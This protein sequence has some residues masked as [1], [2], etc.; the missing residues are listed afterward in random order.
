MSTTRVIDLRSD[1]FTV[2][3]DGM[4]RAMAAAEVGD[5]VWGE[6]PTVNRLEEHVAALL[7]KQAAMY[8]PSGTMGNLVS[9]CAQ[10][11]P[12]DEIVVDR[13]SHLVVYEVAGAAVVGGVQMRHLDPAS[14]VPSAAEVDAAVRPADV[15]QPISRLLCLE[16]TH[17]RRGGA[18]LAAS[19]IAAA[20]GA[21]RRHGMRVHCD[22]AR[23][24]NAAAAL[25]STPAD[26]VAQCD[27][28]SVC[29]SKGLGAPVGSVVAAGAE[30]VAEARRW[31]KRLGGGMRQAGILAAAGLYALEHNVERLHEDHANA[32]LLADALGDVPGVRL[33]LPEV[34]TNIVLALCPRPAVEV[35]EL[36]AAAGVLVTDMGG[37]LLRCMTYLGISRDDAREA[38]SRLHGVL[39]QLA[40]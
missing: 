25:D 2:P 4:R 36:A 18:A 13:E 29:L 30:T 37:P 1:T 28:V 34:P 22:G 32:R 27:S 38:A 9:V 16:N 20:A 19:L 10:T 7:G 31:R 35:V 39:T 8:V 3:D 6:D 14:G 12:G 40:A 26:L 5:D 23:L 17:N 21:A 24:F 11:R 33:Q 15:H